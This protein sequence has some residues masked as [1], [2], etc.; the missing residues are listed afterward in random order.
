[1]R[2][3]FIVLLFVLF[4]ANSNA[5]NNVI[6]CS[7][8]VTTINK[9]EYKK[10]IYSINKFVGKYDNSIKVETVRSL[11]NSGNWYIVDCTFSGVDPAILMLH[12]D[13][14]GFHIKKELSGNINSEGNIETKE[15]IYNY[16]INAI[17]KLSKELLYCASSQIADN[18]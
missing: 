16:F 9:S 14:K 18:W 8:I 13:K 4:S 3:Y 10:L 11:N 1:M 12:R 7:H 2:K 15:V 6:D 5:D 17:P